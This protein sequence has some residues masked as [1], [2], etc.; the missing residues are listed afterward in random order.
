[1]SVG[2]QVHGRSIV[3]LPRV[4]CL[5]DAEFTDIFCF[6]QPLILSRSSTLFETILGRNLLIQF[7]SHNNYTKLWSATTGRVHFILR[8]MPVCCR[9]FYFS[10][11]F[12]SPLLRGT[13][14]SLLRGILK[15]WD[16]INVRPA[17]SGLDRLE[18]YVVQPHPWMT[19][20]YLVFV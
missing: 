17:S 9:Y 12:S 6:H 7:T 18:C 13:S 19:K 20:S 1:M 5:W 2:P 8:E 16:S 11:T 14:I 15:V 10:Y 4:I 3:R